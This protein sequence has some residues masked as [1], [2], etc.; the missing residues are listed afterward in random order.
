VTRFLR[1]VLSNVLRE[2][3]VDERLVPDAPAACLLAE[4]LE[5]TGVDANGDQLPGLVAERGT[6]NAAHCAE[7]LGRRLR[8]V[9]EINPARRTPCA[10]AGSRAA[11]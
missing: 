9:A 5:Y 8:D 6:T 2:H 3:L 4:L 11:R 10:R 7:L 1:D